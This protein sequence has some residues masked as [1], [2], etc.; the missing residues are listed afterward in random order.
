MP[1]EILRDA[2]AVAIAFDSH[3]FAS[4][5]YLSAR[6]GDYGWVAD[7]KFTL[8]FYL[9]R[10]AG[11][12]RLVFT[13]GP[14]AQDT[15]G[16]QEF[17][18]L[19]VQTIR[20]AKLCDFIAKPQS[21]AIFPCAPTQSISA[22]W[23]TYEVRLNISD[24]DILRGF[25][26]KH[27][28]VIRKSIRDGVAI[29]P[30]ESVRAAHSCIRD[31][32]RRQGLRYY[33]S[34]LLLQKLENNLSGRI[35]SFGAFHDGAL[36]G[37]AVVPY[38]RNTGYYLYGGS[39][40]SPHGGSL[41]LLQFEIMRELRNRGVQRYDLFGARIGVKPGTKY[42]GIQRFK[43]R[44]GGELRVGRTFRIVFSPVRYALFN[45]LADLRM[46]LEGKRYVDPLNQLTRGDYE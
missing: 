8:P 28:N 7:A 24:E 17:L 30:L 40:A 18:D 6:S 25:H 1:V 2:R 37:V 9:E 43:A 29:R 32:L 15:Q 31:T 22:P 38:D 5:A 45:R 19:A 34:E 20:K 46:R 3:I 39:V 44:F 21:S 36:Q 26:E 13:S 23:G 42:E 11:V 4:P 14:V 16:M 27:R 35:I 41:N 33:P 12:R 10:I